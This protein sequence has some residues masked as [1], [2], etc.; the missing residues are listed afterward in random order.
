MIPDTQDSIFQKALVNSESG[1]IIL[2]PEGRVI[3]WNDWMVTMSGVETKQ[4]LGKNLQEIFLG[5]ISKRLLEA[6]D[7]ALGNGSSTILS[8]RLNPHPILLSYPDDEAEPIILCL[9][10]QGIVDISAGYQC[11]IEVQDRNAH[12]LHET[13]LRAQGI[14]LKHNAERMMA[15]FN[16]VD[17]GIFL[18]SD[19]G[20]ILQVN[21][22]GQDMLRGVLGERVNGLISSP[23]ENTIKGVHIEWEPSP[24]ELC[25]LVYSATEIIG[26]PPQWAWMIRDETEYRTARKKLEIETQKTHHS[27]KLAT[28]GEMAASIVH[29][30]RNPLAVIHG[31]AN[32]ISRKFNKKQLKDEDISGSVDILFKSADR[33]DKTIKTLLGMSRNTERDPLVQSKIGPIL[34][35]VLLFSKLDSVNMEISIEG[36]EGDL[37][38]KCRPPEISQVLVNLVKNAAD[39]HSADPS[40]WLKIVIE[41]EQDSTLIRVIDSGTGIDDHVAKKIFDSFFSTKKLGKGTGIGLNLCKRIIEEG[42]GGKLYLD[43]DCPNT[44][45]VIELP[46]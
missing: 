32:R 34:D 9:M 23:P 28:V 25:A 10:V 5:N 7:D 44:C 38:I 29:E 35:D 13:F 24:G 40:S 14:E 37:S 15:L 19:T 31:T 6:I 18:T 3:L 1:K 4:A 46:N 12:A 22:I 21:K 26:M 17:C 39:E 8:P 33:I 16:T 30:I 41:K 11:F 27:M 42:H 2:D 43:K 20:S 36:N 45:F